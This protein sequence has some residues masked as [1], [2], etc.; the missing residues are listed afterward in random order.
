MKHI[1][2]FICLLTALP[3]YS[4]TWVPTLEANQTKLFVRINKYDTERYNLLLEREKVQVI[5][6]NQLIKFQNSEWDI[7]RKITPLEKT[8]QYQIDVTFK[9][10]SGTLNQASLS[11]DLEF[12]DWKESNYVLMPAAVYNGNRYE[13]VQMDYSP[14][15]VSQSQIGLDKP[16]LLSDQPR[17]NYKDGYS[18]IQE[19]SGS[20]SL[21]SVGWHSPT[22]KKGFLMHFSQGNNL[23]DYGVDIEENKGRTKA[24]ISLTSPVVREIRL[25]SMAHRGDVFSADVASKDVPANFKKGDKCTI[26]FTANFFD[27]PDIQSLYDKLKEVRI[28]NYPSPESPDLM[29]FSKVFETVEKHKNLENWQ[30][31]GYY[32]TAPITGLG[33]AWQWQP[34]WCGGL[35]TLFPLLAEGTS[36]TK[37][38]VVTNLNWLYPQGMSPSGFYFDNRKDGEF[39]SSKDSKPYGK[40]LLLTRKNADAVYYALKLFALMEQSGIPV[41]Q[42]WKNANSVA[43]KVQLGTWYKHGQLGQYVNQ[44]T[45]ELIVGS[46]AGASI[47]IAALCEEYKQTKDKNMLEVA[48]A[49]GEYFNKKYVTTG[50]TFGAPS[51]AMQSFDSEASYALLESFVELYEATQDKKWLTISKNMASQFAT[52]VTAYDFKFPAHTDYGKLDIRSNGTVFANTQNKTSCGGICT[53]SG[54]ALLKLYRATQDSFHLNLLKDI[55]HAIPQM[56]SWPE[57]QIPGY[58]DGWIFERCNMT[59]FDYGIGMATAGSSWAESAMLLTAIELPGIYVNKDAKKVFV[60]DHVNAKLVGSSELEISNPTK[61]EAVVKLL[62]ETNDEMLKPLGQNAFLKWRKVTVPAGKTITVS[63]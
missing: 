20:M 14:F 33:S 46:G 19:R 10:L 50:L 47:F 22:S 52:W 13:A 5:S 63:L 60:L 59:D 7:T 30:K 16:I 38:R 62:A 39:I 40:D 48:V 28:K 56:M 41:K 27:S 35:L 17:L 15:F 43:L 11:V 12:A 32:S 36:Q 24:T 26:S 9:C 2:F 49:I 54:I 34:G 18:R 53:H 44:Q 1:A 58:N 3:C 29:P 57:H 61:Y 4:Q 8:G 6:N 42:E 21:P 45:G 55:A 51:D 31:E 37:S 25:H 23:G